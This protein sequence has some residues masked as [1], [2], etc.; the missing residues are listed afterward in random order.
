MSQFN[1][2]T[3][4]DT[5][6]SVGKS[7]PYMAPMW[8]ADN[9]TIN[10]L[11]NEQILMPYA[12]ISDTP[13]PQFQNGRVTGISRQSD[14]QIQ[15]FTENNNNSDNIKD[16]ILYGTWVRSTLSDAFFSEK[17]MNN[18]QDLLRYRVYMASGG[19]F[20]IG[21]Q[22]NIEL[23]VI[24]R[25]IFLMYSKSLPDRIT[26]QITELNLQVIDYILPNIISEIKQWIHYSRDLESLP[27]Q[28][29]LPIN[30]SS[31]GTKTLASVTSTF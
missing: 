26:Q 4:I 29:P 15:M 9:N 25:S 7:I 2:I 21:K 18:L 1:R 28:I 6:S 3:N 19:E 11:T 23:T 10:P 12:N 20:Q 31:R 24:M 14:N 22:S 30:V 5:P 27:S 8:G 17:N 13:V 16:T